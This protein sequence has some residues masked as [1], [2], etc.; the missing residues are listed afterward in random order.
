MQST[1]RLIAPS[2]IPS[3]A[4]A[5]SSAP[6]SIDTVA[7]IAQLRADNAS[8]VA[9]TRAMEAAL[10][11]LRPRAQELPTPIVMAAY[12]QGEVV[13]SIVTDARTLEALGDVPAIRFIRSDVSGE[14]TGI[15]LAALRADTGDEY[16]VGFQLL[17]LVG[18]M[19]V[20]S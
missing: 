1:A 13:S 10:T 2:R 3:D 7:M 6:V 15:E 8:L 11:A 5:S 16:A 9:R 19:A 18:G 20:Q 4:P 14:I 17:A 12:G